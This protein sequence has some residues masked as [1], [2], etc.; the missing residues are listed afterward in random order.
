MAY[1]YLKQASIDIIKN[2]QDSRVIIDSGA[3]TAWKAG[4]TIDINEY[5]S[6]IK[7]LPFEPWKYFMLDV[8]GDPNKTKKNYEVMLGQGLHPIP[9]FTRGDDLTELDNYYKTSDIVGVGGLVGTK[10]NNGFVKGI[11]EK[12]NGRKVHLLGFTKADF[13]SY[14]RPYMCDS[15][16][17]AMTL[18]YGTIKLYVGKGKFKSISKKDCIK[19]PTKEII[20]LLEWYGEDYKLLQYAK[21]WKNSG[22]GDS[23]IERLATKS[24]PLFQYDIHKNFNTKYFLAVASELQ[25]QLLYQGFKF[26]KDK[27]I[28]KL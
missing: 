5:C 18:L 10:G 8:I 24:Y 21:Q 2:L 20:D 27:G 15:S 28:I 19:K 26:W 25:I 3:F 6:F 12:I 17:W 14:Y 7:N 9:I 13:I 22:R 23:V 1:P 4:K 11:M 16:S